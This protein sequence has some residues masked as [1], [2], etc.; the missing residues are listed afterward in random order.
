[1]NLM[2]LLIF[3][4]LLLVFLKV[5]IAFSL[6][7]SSI[8]IILIEELPLRV[9]ISQM[10]E[11]VRLF[12]LL[13][14]P[15][16][17]MAGFMMNKGDLTPRLVKLSQNIVG[18]FRGGLAYVNI[19]VSMLFAGISGS[20][21]ADTSAVGGILI[22][23]MEKDGY[24]K[25]FSVAITAASS[26]MGT[27][28]PPSIYM[29]VYGAAAGIS[30]GALFLGGVIPGIL[31][32]LSQMIY[33]Y[34]QAKKN[35]YARHSNSSREILINFKKA[36]LP[37][38]MPFLIVGG[39]IGGVFTAT[40]A[41]AA[42]VFYGFFLIFVVYRTMDWK[43]LYDLFKK[44][45]LFYPVPLFAISAASLF[46]WLVTYLG[47][48]QYFVSALDSLGLGS[49]GAL[50]FLTII[51]I[52]VGTF[53]SPV[54]AI[55]VFIPFLRNLEL[56]MGYNP[57]RLGVIVCVSLSLGLITPPYGLCFLISSQI[58]E[59]SIVRTFK[60]LLPLIIVFILVLVLLI[61]FPALT[62]FFP[63]LIAPHLM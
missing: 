50:F 23:A 27:I 22:P 5:P 56:A 29:V 53:M 17:L 18:K 63:E 13:A 42:A 36:I 15:F 43:D 44:T 45:A 51:L 49:T 9:V 31:I 2:F 62:T 38:L 19:L 33:T 61:I 26:T 48:E 41:G 37:L 60:A 58:G 59:L 28:I 21:A 16:F 20:S 6:A 8:V 32:G 46:G 1:M 39:I 14:I 52:I 25:D 30:I 7:A 10:Y 55:L 47:G 40:E 24:D 3:I 4:F 12:P 11:G 54:A 35:N 57:I 34:F